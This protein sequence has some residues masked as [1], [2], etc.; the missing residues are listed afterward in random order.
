MSKFRLWLL[1]RFFIKPLIRK[2]D[3][4]TMQ[5]WGLIVSRQL[6][7]KFGLKVAILTCTALEKKLLHFLKGLTYGLK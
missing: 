5:R 6:V 4:E 7:K 2:W 3:K 1:W